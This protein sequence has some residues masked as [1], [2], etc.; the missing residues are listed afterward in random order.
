[1][2]NNSFRTCPDTGLKFHGPAENLIKA[3]A[4]AAVVFLLVGGS[5]HG[6]R[7]CGLDV[8]TPLPPSPLLAAIL[9][10]AASFIALGD[11]S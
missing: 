4:V 11:I 8:L 10:L 6:V 1:M 3:N 2:T 7:C 9:D 5:H